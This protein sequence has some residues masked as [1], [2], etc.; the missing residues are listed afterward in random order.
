MSLRICVCIYLYLY[1][2][3]ISIYILEYYQPP[4]KAK[5]TYLKVTCDKVCF[6]T[7]IPTTGL[8]KFY[9]FA[10]LITL[11]QPKNCQMP[12]AGANQTLFRTF[13]LV[14]SDSE[15]EETL[16]GDSWAVFLPKHSGISGLL[17]VQPPSCS[18]FL[19]SSITSSHKIFFFL[20]D[21][22]GFSSEKIKEPWKE[23]FGA[24]S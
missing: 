21:Q 9:I 23:C 11:D 19:T 18:A 15:M 14:W 6:Y 17:P 22:K 20:L 7:P 3:S 8:S 2:K 4:E 24:D 12:Q 13:N 10:D 1:S 5:A 16:G